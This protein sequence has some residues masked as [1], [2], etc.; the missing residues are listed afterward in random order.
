M[1]RFAGWR[2]GAGLLILAFLGGIFIGGAQPVAVGLIPSPWDKLAH[3]LA[4][5]GLAVLLELA[6]RPPVWLLLGVPMLVSAADE[7]HQAFLPG[8]NSGVDDWMAGAI[9]AVLAW[10]LLR[11]TP[12]RGLVDRL[13]S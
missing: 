7:F 13:R 2:L 11:H 6:L 10:W 12:V 1:T 4:F 3:L 8:R 9:G 5:G